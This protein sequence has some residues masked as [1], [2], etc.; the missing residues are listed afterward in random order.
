LCRNIGI[1]HYRLP[2][3][4]WSKSTSG[5]QKPHPMRA[6]IPKIHERE[7]DQQN[8]QRRLCKRHIPPYND[9]RQLEVIPG[10]FHEAGLISLG[11]VIAKGC[12]DT[13]RLAFGIFRREPVFPLKVRH[14]AKNGLANS[15]LHREKRWSAPFSRAVVVRCGISRGWLGRLL[16]CQAVVVI[17]RQA[18]DPGTENL[19]RARFLKGYD[20]I[21]S[22]YRA[23]QWR[24]HV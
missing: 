4:R 7:H 9:H 5:V 22:R 24:I 14:R 6:R 10:S 13:S 18:S 21:F 17:A 3:E 20:R 23:G 1:N 8:R 2:M 11:G 12:A 15:L 16:P 19:R